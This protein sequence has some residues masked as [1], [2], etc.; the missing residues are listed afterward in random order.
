MKEEG[1]QRKGTFSTREA[2]EDARDLIRG[3][4][5][6]SALG[7]PPPTDA[8][9]KPTLGQVLDGYV[10]ECEALNR[11]ASHIRGIRQVKRYAAEL[12]RADLVAP[13]CPS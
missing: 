8:T 2:A 9:P 4:R 12:R 13:A 3:R 11:S 1:R 7:L 10:L 6:A 5:V